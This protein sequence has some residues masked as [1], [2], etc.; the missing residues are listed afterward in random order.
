FRLER[1][2]RHT[3]PREGREQHPL[4]HFLHCILVIFLNTEF[5]FARQD[6]AACLPGA[7]QTSRSGEN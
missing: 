5:T 6:R 2:V 4:E 1:L 7:S 3:A